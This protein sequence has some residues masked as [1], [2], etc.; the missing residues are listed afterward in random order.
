M[1]FMSRINYRA[2]RY[3]NETFY[4]VTVVLLIVALFMPSD[5][6]GCY[7]WVYFPGGLSL[8]PSEMA[9]FSIILGTADAL[10]RRKT[11]SK[12]PGMGL[13]CRLCP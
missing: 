3:L 8:Q 2:L 9:K 5:S 4:F 7:R 13:Y 10:D 12:I 6:N 11:R 1:L